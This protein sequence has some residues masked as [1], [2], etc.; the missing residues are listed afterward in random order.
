[1]LKN[2]LLMASKVYWRRKMFTAINLMCIVLTLVVLLVVTAVMEHSFAPSGVDVNRDR[3]V[4]VS[5]YTKFGKNM[6]MSNGL[7]FKL[8]ELYLK[9]IASAE[10]VSAVTRPIPVAV[11]QDNHVEKLSMRFTDATYW[12]IYR[13]ALLEGR[14]L[15][16]SDVED[17]RSVVVLNKVIANKLFGDSSAVG[18]KLNVRSHQYEVVGVVDDGQKASGNPE[19]WAPHSS[20]PSSTYRSS[21]T[22]DFFAVLMARSAADLPMLKKDV[23]DNGRRII[24]EDP[25]KSIKTLLLANTQFDTF[26]RGFSSDSRSE[27]SGAERILVWIMILMFLFMLLPAL[28]LVNLNLGRMMER[29]AEIGVRKAFGAS[30]LALVKQFLIE[31][32]VLSIIGCVIALIVTHL[33]LTWVNFTGFLPSLNL[34][35]NLSVFVYGLIVTVVFGVVSGVVP[36]LRMARLDP[37][38]ALKGNA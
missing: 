34:G 15:Q 38:Y 18:K 10:R 30:T 29:S 3:I 6:T 13:Y 26:A 21:L 31:N 22:G 35:V 5:H 24:D 20:M 8:I 12:E 33:F 23:L 36:A 37:V 1:M 11:Y 9:P 16:V 14:F 28:N 27:D 17:G 2:Y 4:T 32:I 19:M 25:S 7:G